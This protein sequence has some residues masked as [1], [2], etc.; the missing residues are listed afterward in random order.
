MRHRAHTGRL[1]IDMLNQH[2]DCP[3]RHITQWNTAQRPLLPFLWFDDDQ[4]VLENTEEICCP[5][6]SFPQIGLCA[7]RPLP[8]ALQNEFSV[9][10]RETVLA[11]SRCEWL[12]DFFQQVKQCSEVTLAHAAHPPV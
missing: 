8:N 10:S 7:S 5:Q 2:L 12:H 4:E 3:Q 11:G 1:T 6:L 9:T